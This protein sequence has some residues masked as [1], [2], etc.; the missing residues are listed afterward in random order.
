MIVAQVFYI[1]SLLGQ[2]FVQGSSDPWSSGPSTGLYIVGEHPQATHYSAKNTDIYNL[3]QPL[4]KQIATY[5]NHSTIVIAKGTYYLSS[6][7]EIG[8]NCHLTGYGIDNSILKLVDFATKFSKAGFIRSILTANVTIS[9]ITLDGNK[10]HQIIDEGDEDAVYA[11]FE[12]YGRYG[13]FTEGSTNV[14]F[15]AVK[16]TNFQYYGFDPHGQKKTLIYGN[17]LVIKNCIASHNTQDGYTLDQSLNILVTNCTS[18]DNGRH[19][20][21]V[22]TGSKYTV[23]ENC[24]SIN[25]GYYFSETSSGCGVAIQNNQ[26]FGTH[27][28]VFRNMIIIDPKKAGVCMNGVYNIIV[29]NN[30]ITSR[31]CMRVESTNNTLIRNNTCINSSVTRRILV[32]T[33]SNNVSVSNTTYLTNNNVQFSGIAQVIKVGYSTNATKVVTTENAYNIIQ[34]ALDTLRYNGGGILYI[35]E[36]I[37]NLDSY[38]E[39]GGNTSIIG[40]GMNKTILR[41]VDY[42]SPWWIPGTG[43]KR[44]GFIRATYVHNLRFINFTIDGNRENQ[45]NDTY[46][47]YGRYGL[48]TEACNDVFVDGMAIKNFQGY[49]FDPHG[50]KATKTWSKNLTIINSYSGF[51]AWDGYTIDQSHNVILMNNTAESNGRHGFNIVTGSENVTMTNNYAI[52]NGFTYY[53]E[54]RGCGFMIQ[55]NLNYGTKNVNMTDNRIFNSSDAGVCA[56]DVANI[57]I[58]NNI[59]NL[60]SVRS[61]IRVRNVNIGLITYNECL[62]ASRGVLLTNSTVVNVFNNTIM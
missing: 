29:E 24:T 27:S 36:G 41:L 55:N 3:L 39:V 51:N 23:I 50:V 45:N 35:E 18:H 30:T 32:D 12:S 54:T 17:G 25:D 46:S 22:V 2:V 1:W 13:I 5:E 56:T 42:A 38:I 7:I 43:N 8:S 26:N 62:N 52:G 34:Q 9:N 44:S 10:H 40:A 19:G 57:I 28:A 37:Y 6:N 48:Y 60:T 58:S 4:F 14:T 59:I 15:D 33:L 47:E 31:T 11:N 16:V 49:G 53:M 21:N 20:F 61:C